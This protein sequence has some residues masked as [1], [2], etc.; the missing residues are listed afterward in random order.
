[1]PFVHT[2]FPVLSVR[3][4]IMLGM[5]DSWRRFRGFAHWTLTQK[6]LHGSIAGLTA[7]PNDVVTLD[8]RLTYVERRCTICHELVHIERGRLSDDDR[9]TAR[10]EPLVKREVAHRLV[11]RQSLGQALAWSWQ[12]RTSCG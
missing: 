7:S 2:G 11:E 10:V 1:M 12:I 4:G 8:H 3:S 9:L 5:H 6:S